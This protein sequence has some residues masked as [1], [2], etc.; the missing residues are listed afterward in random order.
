MAG[1]YID[2]KLL[3]GLSDEI[4]VKALTYIGRDLQ[5]GIKRQL[6]SNS[7]KNPH[8]L[9]G[10]P[11]LVHGATTSPLK[12]LVNFV[13]DEKKK[14]VVAGPMV[15]E[16]SKSDSE[17]PVPNILERGGTAIAHVVEYRNTFNRRFRMVSERWKSKASR[18]RG[19]SSDGF[20]AWKN[21][22]KY[23]VNKPVLILPRP[24]VSP[25]FQ[26]YL[27]GDGVR[28]AIMRARGLT[29]KKGYDSAWSWKKV[30]AS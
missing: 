26:R 15:F 14:T 16:Q 6:K 4:A 17:K 29:K 9:P 25:T 8:S 30:D 1:Y 10:Q 22:Y 5:Q 24:F 7:K 11:P 28:K 21:K 3:K 12:R 18:K 20:R 13:V 2:R 27:D 23:E 19:L